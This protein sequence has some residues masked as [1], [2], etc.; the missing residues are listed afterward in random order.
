MR[1]LLLY[2][3]GFSSSGQS[4][5]ALAVGE[6]VKQHCPHMDYLAPSFPNYPAAAFNAIKEII[7]SELAQGREKIGMIGSS[8][9]GFMA[10]MVGEL[11]QLKAVLVNPAVKPSKLMPVLLGENTNFH[12][13]EKFLLTQDHLQELVEIECERMQYPENY[14]LMLQTGDETLNYRWAK[15]YYSKSPQHIEE[16]G[17]HRF[18]NFEQHLPAVLEFL[19]LTDGH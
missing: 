17:N 10:T 3:H 8:L 15:K 13:G 4:E 2:I 1:P 9:G 5:K 11:Y 12:T 16:G 7:E 14:W 6:F 18:E 19:E